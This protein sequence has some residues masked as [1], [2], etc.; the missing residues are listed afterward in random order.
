MAC[1]RRRSYSDYS[2]CVWPISASN[3]R[4][5]RCLIQR[6]QSAAQCPTDQQH[7][8]MLSSSSNRLNCLATAGSLKATIMVRLVLFQRVLSTPPSADCDFNG[9]LPMVMYPSLFLYWTWGSY[10]SFDKKK[11]GALI[12]KIR[13][14]LTLCT[15]KCSVTVTY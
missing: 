6:V 11:I 14:V 13:S 3:G 5:Q 8:Q 4:S 9:L 7:Q 12:Y 10:L 1:C 2:E 15:K